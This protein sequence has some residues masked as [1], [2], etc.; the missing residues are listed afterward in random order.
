MVRILY[1][2]AGTLALVLGLIGLFLP[3]L[4]TTPFLLLASACYMRGSERLAK[5]MITNRFFGRYLQDFQSNR[6]IPVK[7]KIWALAL[8]WT[9]LAIS[10]Y[11]LPLAWMRALL[12]IPGCGVT[13]Y[14]LR[15][16]T[17]PVDPPETIPPD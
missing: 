13:V 16:K 5:W 14:L 7:T 1:T 8:M 3:L 11:V 6:G 12:L 4:P 9:S 10:A 17:R 15:Y 2:I